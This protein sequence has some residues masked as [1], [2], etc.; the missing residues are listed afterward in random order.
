MADF[1]EVD[2]QALETLG[3]RVMRGRGIETQDVASAPWVAV[4]NKS[5]ADRHFPGQNP[6]GQ[7]IQVWIGWGGQPG[8]I[9][10][11]QTGQSVGVVADVMSPSYF[12]ETPAVMY[13]PLPA[14][15]GEQAAKTSGCTQAR[16]SSCGRPSI[17]RRS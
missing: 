12:P 13:R 15:L 16:R 11:P 10:K 9:E 3:I 5:F 17:R 1:T 7:A 6:L 8:T 14:A 4:I 2:P